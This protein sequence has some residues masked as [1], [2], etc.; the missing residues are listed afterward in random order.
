MNDGVPN[1]DAVAKR[2]CELAAKATDRPAS[3]ILPSMEW[4]RDVFES[5]DELNFILDCEAEFGVDLSNEQL[6][7]FNRERDRTT[8]LVLQQ[9]AQFIV[10]N[11]HGAVTRCSKCRYDLTGL[12]TRACPEC[13]LQ[14]RQAWK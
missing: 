14:H 11:W 12:S 4:D 7:R 1:V 3:E 8:P 5:L 2:V 6:A 10:E 13:G 9:F